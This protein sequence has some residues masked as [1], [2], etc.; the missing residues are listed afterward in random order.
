M[1]VLQHSVLRCGAV[2]RIATDC[3][4]AAQIRA[5]ETLDGN[6]LHC[7]ALQDKLFSNLW[8]LTWGSFD[9]NDAADVHITWRN[10]WSHM[11]GEKARTKY[12]WLHD[13]LKV[14]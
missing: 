13:S 10:E 2:Q 3:N 6:A 1:Y 9:P 11:F 7:A 14:S 4:A 5:P 12:I 8:W